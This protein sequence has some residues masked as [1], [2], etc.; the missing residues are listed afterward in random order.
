MA[1]N[2]K[3]GLGTTLCNIEK[4]AY[5]IS[6]LQFWHENLHQR[7]WVCSYLQ[8]WHNSLQSKESAYSI[9]FTILTQWPVNKE[10]VSTPSLT[11]GTA[12]C[13]QR[14]SA[15]SVSYKSGTAACNQRESAYSISYTILVRQPAIQK[16]VPTPS[17]LQY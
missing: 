14:E 13:N 16:R 6:I 17:L 15:Y 1:C 10:R 11:S 3:C 5:S 9:S 2:Q 7:E 4:S 8:I 12:A